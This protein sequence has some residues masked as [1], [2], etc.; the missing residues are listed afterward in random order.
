M[1]KTKSVFVSLIILSFFAGAF[2]REGRSESLIQQLAKSPVF[3]HPGEV[4]DDAAPIFGNAVYNTAFQWFIRN[5]KFVYG[6][7]ALTIGPA[8]VYIDALGNPKKLP[9]SPKQLVLHLGSGINEVDQKYY[10]GVIVVEWKGKGDLR[11]EGYDRLLEKNFDATWLSS[12]QASDGLIQSSPATGMVLNGMRIYQVKNHSKF[13]NLVVHNATI[14]GADAIKDIRVWLNDGGPNAKTLRP[15]IQN[16]ETVFHPKYIEIIKQYQ[17]QPAIRCM[18]FLDTVANPQ[19]DWMDRRSPLALFQVGIISNRD[20]IQ[21]THLISNVGEME[22]T[23]P[24][25]ETLIS[26]CNQTGKDLWINI[27]HLASN[28]YI[29]NLARLIFYGSN[30]AGNPYSSPQAN[31]YHKPLNSTLRVWVEYSNEIWNRGLYPQ[32]KWMEA[33]AAIANNT[34][35]PTWEQFAKFNAGKVSQVWEAFEGAVP[36][37]RANQRIVRLAATFSVTSKLYTKHFIS[38]L[39]SKGFRPD[40]VAC[41]TYIASGMDDW[42]KNDPELMAHFNTSDYFNPNNSQLKADLDAFFVEWNHRVLAYQEGKYEV[43]NSVFFQGGV[44]QDL[45]STVHD[46]LWDP[47]LGDVPIV[48]YEGGPRFKLDTIDTGLP[49]QDGITKFFTCV[50]RDPRIAPIYRLQLNLARARG[51]VSHMAFQM[52]LQPSRFGQW[53]HVVSYAGTDFSNLSS[54]PKQK[55]IQDWMDEAKLLRPD[56]LVVGNAPAFFTPAELPTAQVGLPYYQKA[57]ARMGERDHAF[58]EIVGSSMIDGLR[59]E[60]KDG[61]FLTV[62]GT[63]REEGTSFICVR[64]KDAPSNTVGDA[65]WRVFSIR[66]VHSKEMAYSTTQTKLPISFDSGAINTVDEK[67]G[68]RSGGFLFSTYSIRDRFGATDEGFSFESVGFPSRVLKVK[69]VGTTSHGLRIEPIDGFSFDLKSLKLC[70]PDRIYGSAGHYYTGSATIVG[71]PTGGGLVKRVVELTHPSSVLTTVNLD[72][73]SMD[74]VEIDFSPQSQGA[75]GFIPGVVDDVIVNQVPTITWK[76]ADLGIPMGSGSFSQSGDYFELT[77]GGQGIQGTS[78][79]GYFVRP[80]SYHNGFEVKMV[81]DGQLTAKIS[82]PE[83][84][85]G[86]GSLGASAL[87]GLMV[88]TSL[89]QASDY[90]STVLTADKRVLRQSRLDGGVVTSKGASPLNVTQTKCW[91]RLKRVGNSFESSY[92][93]DNQTW[94]LIEKKVWSNAPATLYMGLISTPSSAISMS[95]GVFESVEIK[96]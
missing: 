52:I 55:A 29:Q 46:E 23:G 63:P 32:A 70:L 53:G 82:I 13:L 47:L 95:K 37:A 17:G 92:S 74:K 80:L 26:L 56:A 85:E 77:G 58:Q 19:Q 60:I 33:Q 9:A 36:S 16:G 62:T 30:Q 35:T 59:A 27:P 65:T 18:D 1:K 12:H 96:E 14:S 6:S 49:G 66:S 75:G 31:P 69:K 67:I 90:L 42:V 20:P 72:W 88:R 21:P 7:N 43:P 41:T 83:S 57:R 22:L 61:K 76:G 39:K 91:L 45:K 5:N 34:V 2:T 24:A 79:T 48:A 25:Y 71:F 93:L 38:T 84:A 50:S 11:L 44:P 54:L 64:A 28:A 68:Y 86:F 78:D 4:S 73:L 87:T 10:Q 81:S 89:D 8:N 3:V 51:V 15:A 40:A 94:V